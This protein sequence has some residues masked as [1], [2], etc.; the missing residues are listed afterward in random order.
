MGNSGSRRRKG[1]TETIVPY[2]PGAVYATGGAPSSF[3]AHPYSNFNYLPTF[4]NVDPLQPTYQHPPAP[5]PSSYEYSSSLS[6]SGERMRLSGENYSSASAPAVP[7]DRR[8]TASILRD[9]ALARRLQREE[10]EVAEE[11]RRRANIAQ[12]VSAGPSV[13]FRATSLPT[14]PTIS[15]PPQSAT[16]VISNRSA[17]RPSHPIS[18]STSSALSSRR[19]VGRSGGAGAGAGAGG[20]TSELTQQLRVM[21]S[22][23]VPRALQVAFLNSE[24]DLDP[25]TFQRLIL[26]VD[27]QSSHVPKGASKETVNS[28]PTVPFNPENSETLG[29]QYVSLFP[30]SFSSSRHP[31]FSSFESALSGLTSHNV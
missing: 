28:L 13:L 10:E 20:D 30:S 6:S 1:H 25:A 9:E 4:P 14:L 5:R 12:P 23:G 15:P 26:L 24:G 3:P 17:R 18:S 31:L 21:Q 19:R 11:R 7:S 27:A 2:Y 22:M 29:T 16:V 8:S